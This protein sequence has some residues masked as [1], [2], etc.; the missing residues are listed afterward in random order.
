MAVSFVVVSLSQEAMDRAQDRFYTHLILTSGEVMVSIVALEFFYTQ[1]PKRIPISS[2]SVGRKC[3]HDLNSHLA[4]GS[5]GS[6]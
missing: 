4:G 1:A 6:R 3:V 2:F 5:F